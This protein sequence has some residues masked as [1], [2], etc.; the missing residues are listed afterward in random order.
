[1]SLGRT[2]AAAYAVLVLVVV[3]APAVVVRA[4]GDRGAGA[5]VV[6]SADL[7]GAGAV[8][9][10]VAAVVAWR[11][12]SAPGAAGPASRWIAALGALGVLA[13]G[14]TAVPTIA[15]HAVTG[16]P[17]GPTLAPVLWAGALAVAVLCAET[18]R[19]RLLRWLTD[20]ETHG[21]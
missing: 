17:D 19:R 13:T 2:A 9:G 7:L 6:G 1:M 20:E 11:R 16:V 10:V 5:G 18:V 8:V 3:L 4:A 14:A 12:V 15:L 21:R